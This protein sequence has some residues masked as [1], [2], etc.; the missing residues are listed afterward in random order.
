MTKE[1]LAAKAASTLT[2]RLARCDLCPR[3]CGANRG[4]GERGFCRAG[5]QPVVYSFGPHHGEEPPISG[6]RGSGTIFFSG[7]TMM[8]VYCQNYH[9]SQLDKGTAVTVERLAEITLELQRAGCHNINLVSPTQYVPQIA[10]ALARATAAGLSIPI[11]YNTSGYESLETLQALDGLVDIYLPDMRYADDTVAARYSSA[12]DYVKHDRRAVLEMQRQVGDL[13]CDKDGI[14]TRGLIIR[15]LVLPEH[16]SGTVDSLRFIRDRV[17]PA[18]HLSIMSQYYPTYR[19]RAFPKLS[20]TVSREVYQNVIDEAVR[21]GLN[22]G[23]TQEIPDEP[24]TS[25]LG[26]NIRPRI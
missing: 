24:D 6:N 1:T 20:H 16:L 5:L 10:A 14:A 13:T 9:F 23:W 11:V 22:N 2:R 3:R 12:A 19:A 21:L 17:S 26:T 7:C 15:L 25:F 18:A 8:C 4:A